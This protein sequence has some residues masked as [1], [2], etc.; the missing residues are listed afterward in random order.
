MAPAHPPRSHPLATPI[1]LVINGSIVGD[2]ST[3]IYAALTL[4]SS[5][6]WHNTAFDAIDKRRSRGDHGVCRLAACQY[7]ING[8]SRPTMRGSGS[9]RHRIHSTG[10]FVL[11]HCATARAIFCCS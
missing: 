4:E 2:G 7:A 11:S 5:C 9:L 8:V 10:V 3:S 6:I 1:A